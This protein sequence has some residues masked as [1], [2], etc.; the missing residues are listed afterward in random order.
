MDF[1]EK[2]PVSNGYD[3]IL[4]FV[5]RL[6]KMAAF[7]PT[8]TTLRTK[9]LAQLLLQHVV[10][11]H[12]LPDDLVSDRGS[13]FV[14]KFW[15]TFTSKFNIKRNLSTAYHPES[16]GQTE[17]VN[18]SLEQYLRIYCSYQQDDW[19]TL[20]PI[21]ELVYNNAEHAS[22]HETPFYANYGFHPSFEVVR[23]VNTSPPGKAYVEE[24]RGVH[25]R[26]RKHLEEVRETQKRNADK[27]RIDPP[28]FEVGTKVYLN[29]KNI[30]TTRPTRKFAEKHLGPF[31]IREKVGTVAYRLE[32]PAELS[33]LH[34]VFHVSLL[35]P[36]KPSAIPNRTTEPPPPV[37]IDG[38][39]TWDIVRIVDSKYNGTKRQLEYKVEWAGYEGTEQQ[40]TWEPED[41]CKDVPDDLED[42][43]TKYP[44]KPGP[45]NTPAK[46][47]KPRKKRQ[48]ESTN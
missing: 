5:D 42:F 3:S 31:E 23:G 1:I 34:P 21:A 11:K 6:T 2:L 38:E 35:E 48:G 29:S 44:H 7:I 37:E 24:V 28:S 14:S 20:L 12:G 25:E 16:D 40:Y 8:T 46:T 30:R 17:R 15:K 9:G 19:D 45:H 41:Y 33:R 47:R 43:H 39:E 4:V 27:H 26:V 32:L 22:T 36:V 13:K 10:S 18:Q